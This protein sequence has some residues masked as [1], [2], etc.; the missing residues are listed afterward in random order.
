MWHSSSRKRK[1]RGYILKTDEDPFICNV[2]EER[3]KRE[4][5]RTLL[6]NDDE[7]LISL[8]QI[9]CCKLTEEFKKAGKD[10]WMATGIKK[11]YRQ[12]KESDF[13]HITGLLIN[14]LLL[15]L[16]V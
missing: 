12:I 11:S 10:Y 6:C 2:T 15:R 3:K 9:H 7:R 13:P 16:Q 14:L 1:E 5:G 4:E 8:L